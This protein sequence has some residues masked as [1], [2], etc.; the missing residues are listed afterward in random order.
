MIQEC[1]AFMSFLLDGFRAVTWQQGVMY[2]DRLRAHLPRHPKDYDSA[3]AADDFGASSSTAELRILNQ[4]V[5]GIGET[6]ASSVAL[7]RP[8]VSPAKRCRC[9][10]SSASARCRASAHCSRIPRCCSS[11]LA[12][13]GIFTIVAAIPAR[14]RPRQLSRLHRHHRHGGRVGSL[15]S[16]IS[17]FALGYVI[18]RCR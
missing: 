12:Q 1:V 13:F 6:R 7:R 15:P 9:C 3:A 10:C 2:L 5:R 17:Q 4:M 11:R 14:L 8:A 16:S 18:Y